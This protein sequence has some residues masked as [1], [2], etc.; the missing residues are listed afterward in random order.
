MLRFLFIDRALT[1]FALTDPQYQGAGA[2]GEDWCVPSLERGPST[3]T[4]VSVSICAR[5]MEGC[6]SVDERNVMV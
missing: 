1:L 3:I 6:H 2:R 5:M 4:R